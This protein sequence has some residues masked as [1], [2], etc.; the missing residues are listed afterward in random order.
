MIKMKC[1]LVLCLIIT[2]ISLAK[3]LDYIKNLG[4]WDTKINYKVNLQGGNLFLE[5][6]TFTYLFY[7]IASLEH[8]HEH[9]EHTQEDENQL[10]AYSFK[11]ELLNANTLALKAGINKRMEYHNYFIG[12]NRDKWKGK[13]PLFNGVK[14]SSIYKG[15]DLNLYSLE[16]NLKYDFIVSPGADPDQIQLQYNHI[17]NSKL[18]NG[19][20]HLDLGFNTIIEQKPY[21]FQ[22][23]NGNRVEV[24]CKYNYEN[25]SLSFEFPNG[26]DT[27]YELIIDPVLIASTLS[28]STVTNYGHSATYD[29]EGNI[30]TGA[31]NFG[32][33]YPTSTGAFQV[34]FGGGG[35]DIAVSKLNPDGSSLIWATFIGGN[36]SEY[37]HSMYVSNTNELYVYGSSNSQDYPF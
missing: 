8:H 28:G 29:N 13:V 10:D 31:R 32:S 11:V 12:N 35:T 17:E 19:E 21:A 25:N 23:I 33:G 4:Q 14:Y 18:V 27:K 2:N 3:G 24:A 30:Y 9:D 26:Y 16:L 37:P 15:I 7:D 5:N 36:N 22:N 1:C 20:L 34:N 6:T